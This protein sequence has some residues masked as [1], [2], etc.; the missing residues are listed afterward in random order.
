MPKKKMGGGRKA[1]GK[2]RY[3]E[4]NV[5]ERRYIGMWSRIDE[6]SENETLL[7]IYIYIRYIGERRGEERREEKR[8]D[9]LKTD[10][11]LIPSTHAFFLCLLSLHQAVATQGWN[12]FSD[13]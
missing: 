10:G 13:L 11:G 9:C 2:P 1:E 8:R 4:T 7:F 3:D 5:W 6:R 12:T